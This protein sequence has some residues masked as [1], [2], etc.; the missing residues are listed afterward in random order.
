MNFLSTPYLNYF[1]FSIV[2][3]KIKPWR[4]FN[5]IIQNLTIP[6]VS[7]YLKIIYALINAYKETSIIDKTAEKMWVIQMLTLRNKEN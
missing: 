2:N 4:Y 7:S 1:L 6:F 5:Q 3:E